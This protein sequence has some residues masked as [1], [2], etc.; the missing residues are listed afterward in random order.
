MKIEKV[1]KLA[2]NL[3]DRAEFFILIRNLKEAVNHKLAFKKVKVI[4][5]NRNVL[6]KP[7]ID[8][9]KDIRKKGN[10]DFEK[11]IFKLMTILVFEKNDRPFL[12]KKND[13]SIKDEKTG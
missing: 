8:I 1:E 7:Y 3:H 2:A 12:E 13:K 10:N 9:N 6:L 11:D 4:K 5:F